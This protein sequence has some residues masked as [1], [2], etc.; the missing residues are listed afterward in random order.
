MARNSKPL[1]LLVINED[2]YKTDEMQAFQAKGHE[3]TFLALQGEYDKVVGF[4]CHKLV[5]GFDLGKQLTLME[6]GMRAEKYPKKGA[7]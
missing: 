4:D 6:K 1:K 7:A 2:L 3:V 5:R